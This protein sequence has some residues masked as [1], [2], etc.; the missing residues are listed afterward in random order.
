M[1]SERSFAQITSEDLKELLA[2]SQKRLADYF[3]NGKGGKW[4]KLYDIK[5]PLCVALCQGA[6]LHF[7]DKKNGV[8]DFDVWFFYPFN[9]IHLP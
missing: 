2:G 1:I 8:K 6:A 7:Y 4:L 5:K 9:Q 3:I